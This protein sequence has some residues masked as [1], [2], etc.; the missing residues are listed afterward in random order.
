MTVI[1]EVCDI[2]SLTLSDERKLQIS[3][4]RAVM[5]I[6]QSQDEMKDT[7]ATYY[8]TRT[9]WLYIGCYYYSEMLISKL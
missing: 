9:L 1:L 5:Q 7:L 2:W 8:I 3:E 4:N 6:F